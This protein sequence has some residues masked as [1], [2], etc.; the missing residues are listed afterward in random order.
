MGYQDYP[1]HRRNNT[2]QKK[3]VNH[4]IL[5]RDSKK[6]GHPNQHTNGYEKHAAQQA[7]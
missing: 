1:D 5:R 2:Q 7:A 4:E 3:I 6:R